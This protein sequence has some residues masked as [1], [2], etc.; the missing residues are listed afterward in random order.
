M[1]GSLIR[2]SDLRPPLSLPLMLLRL[3]MLLLLGVVL[4]QWVDAYWPP[5]E[6]KISQTNATDHL[7]VAEMP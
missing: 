7:P 2:L 1:K 3:V 6:N 4:M 5:T